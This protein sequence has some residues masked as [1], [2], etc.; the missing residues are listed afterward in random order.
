MEKIDNVAHELEQAD[1]AWKE[2][3]SLT[4][5]MAAKEL[6]DIGKKLDTAESRTILSGIE[7][8][9]SPTTSESGL[10]Y[11]RSIDILFS[12]NP[13]RHHARKV[14]GFEDYIHIKLIPTKKYLEK[15][16]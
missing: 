7:Q 4:A 2:N 8:L 16:E 1:R 15:Q 14:Y 9:L 12:R 11:V 10:D 3:I 5:R 6:A 13:E